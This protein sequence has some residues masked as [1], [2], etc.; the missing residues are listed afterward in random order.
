MTD[1]SVSILY[2][3]PKVDSFAAFDFF[4]VKTIYNPLDLFNLEIIDLTKKLLLKK[5]KKVSCWHSSS[6]YCAFLDDFFNIKSIG[7]VADQS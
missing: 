4:S 3:T 5:E 2:E 7:A 1:S 6:S